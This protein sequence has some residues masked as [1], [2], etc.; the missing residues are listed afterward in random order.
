MLN[1]IEGVL[2]AATKPEFNKQGAKFRGIERYKQVEYVAP[3]ALPAEELRI[4]LKRIEKRLEN[5]SKT[6]ARRAKTVI[7]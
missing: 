4:T 7:P 5:L 6:Y 1:E 2:I 3:E